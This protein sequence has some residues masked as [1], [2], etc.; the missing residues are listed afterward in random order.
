[1]VT[2]TMDNSVYGTGQCSHR[3]IQQLYSSYSPR[4]D[5]QNDSEVGSGLIHMVGNRGNIFGHI[6]TGNTAAD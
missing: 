3:E 6:P 5:G 1:M 2:I 4:A